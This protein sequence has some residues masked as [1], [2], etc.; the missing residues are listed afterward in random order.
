MNP[1]FCEKSDRSTARERQL[2]A[3]G[4]IERTEP[5]A[6]VH[7]NGDDD[8]L[9]LEVPGHSEQPPPDGHPSLATSV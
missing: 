1:S 9:P 2:F 5:R 3:R 8:A 4:G 7:L 6:S